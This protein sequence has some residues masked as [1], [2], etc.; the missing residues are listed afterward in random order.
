MKRVALLAMFA[1]FAMPA[2]AADRTVTGTISD[3][4]CGASHKK[5]AEHG[6]TKMTDAQCTEA[7]VKAG[8]KYVFV[9]GGK[10]YEI[11]NQDDKNLAANAGKAVRVTGDFEGT[12][13]KVADVAAAAKPE[14]K[15]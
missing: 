9:S 4:S 12:T 14:Q 6:T 5:M 13:V 7:C 11:S 8:G 1:S 3:S 15:N 10:V 2:L